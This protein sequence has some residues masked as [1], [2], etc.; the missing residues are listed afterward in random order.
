MIGG[1]QVDRMGE[2]AVD[3]ARIELLRKS[4]STVKRAL[5]G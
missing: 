4:T 5:S 3:I 2:A 1:I